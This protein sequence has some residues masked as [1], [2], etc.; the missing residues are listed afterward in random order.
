V[1]PAV[2]KHYHRFL[3]AMDSGPFRLVRPVVLAGAANAMLFASVDHSQAWSLASATMGMGLLGAVLTRQLGQI[4]A[5]E[6]RVATG[7]R[8]LS[9]V[10]EVVSALNSSPNVGSTLGGAFD[11][12]VG[13]L[14]VDGG[15]IWLPTPADPREM[16]LVEHRG[17]S[18]EAAPDLLREIRD[19]LDASAGAP[20]RGVC[21]L[22]GQHGTRP[23]QSLAVGM[24][25][26]GEPLGYVCLLRRKGEFGHVETEIL[27]AVATDIGNALRSVRLI[28]EAR[29]LA[30]RDPVTGLHNHR[31]VY[32]RLHSEMERHGRSGKPL[33]IL[34]MDLD[35]F[36]LFNDTYGHPAGDEVLKRVAGVLRR[37][38]R[39]SDVVARFGGD[40]FLMILPETTLKQAIRCA[41]RVATS[42][43]KE[44]FR[45][46]DSATLPIGFSYGI[47]VFPDDSQEA[48]ELVAR[49]DANLYQSKVQGGGKI[50][51]RGAATLENMLS[52]VNGYD[53]FRAMVIAIDNK[54]GYTRKHSEEVTEYSL[55]IAQ[56]LGLSAE[57]LQT[58]Q[59][60]GILHDVGKI[61]VPDS[62]LKKPGKLTDEEFDLMKQHPVFGAVIVGSI[63][64]MDE[65][66]LGVRHH[67]ERYDGRG[68]PDGLKGE[69]IPLIGRIMAVAD[70]YSAMTTCR[71]YR[72]GLTQHQALQEIRKNLG[73]QFDPRI[74]E[75]FI[76]LREKGATLELPDGSHT[77]GTLDIPPADARPKRAPRKRKPAAELV[78]AA[79]ES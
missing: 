60:S 61:G 33:S 8:Q 65:V 7:V 45:C 55:Q 34:M 19:G 79:P 66:V 29:R 3:R 62:I 52:N 77:A 10:S 43:G 40:E 21:H 37:S 50:T 14:E 64:G 6:A 49:A 76:A 13:A 47:A 68:Y 5:L 73:A 23:V 54:D 31:A 27:S 48:Q 4:L 63:A 2:V 67:H 17:I 38:C 22:P 39:E 26:E 71:P 36:K 9:V 32:Q 18:E 69:E 25:R 59:V 53:L 78:T 57:T 46:E 35:N 41:E 56:A 70:A 44:R 75:V 58:I 1:P 11:K 15:A 30:D 28:S 51:V 20:Y 12:L 42:I 24:C 16:A 74:G 72:K